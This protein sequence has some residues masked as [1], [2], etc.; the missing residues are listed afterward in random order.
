MLWDLQE[1]IETWHQV[2]RTFGQPFYKF[3]LILKLL[4]IVDFHLELVDDPK[5]PVAPANILQ[6]AH[7]FLHIQVPHRLAHLCLKNETVIIGLFN[8]TDPTPAVIKNQ[9]FVPILHG[10]PTNL[11]VHL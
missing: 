7:I 6:R 1:L 2:I 3:F 11:R 10:F 4:P 5:A 8:F 9:N